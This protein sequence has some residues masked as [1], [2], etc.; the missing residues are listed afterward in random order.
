M[1]RS[2]RVSS[3]VSL[4][5]APIAAV[6][7]TQADQAAETQTQ[8]AATALQEIV[9]TAQKRSEKLHDVPMGVTA[10]TSDDLQKQDLVSFADLEAKVPGLSVEQIQPGQDRLAIRGQNVGSVGSTVTTYL[11]GVPFGSSNALANGSIVTGD[12]D[13]WDLQR[14]EVLRGPQG[15]LYGAGSEGGLLKYVTNLPDPSREAG[16]F[17]VGGEDIAHGDTTESVKGM[18]NMPITGSA[19]VRI[20][21]FYDGVP[22]YIDDPNLGKNDVNGGYRQGGHV[23]FLVQ[24]SDNFSLRLSAFGQTLH[25]DGTPY[26]DVIGAAGTPLTPP[27]NQLQPSIGDYDQMRFTNEPSTFRY[28]IFALDLDWNLGWGTLSSTSSY[29]TSIQ[30][31]YTDASSVALAP[32]FTFGDLA[33]SITGVPTGVAETNDLT[34]DKYTEELRLASSG[35]Q[36]LEW[37]VGAFYTHEAS[38]LSQSLP[39]FLIPSQANTGLPSLETP[40]LDSLYREQSVF[41][42]ITYHF[43]PQWDVALGGRWSENEQSTTETIG[44]LLVNPSQLD[45]GSSSESDFTYSIAPRWHV[46]NDTMVYARVAS[47]YRPGGPNALPPVAPAGVAASY[48]SDSTVNYELG[49]RTS[50]MDNRLSIDIDAFLVDWRKIQL[51]QIVDNF[52]INANGG[53]AESKG[54]EWTLG[55]TPVQGLNFTLTGDYVDAYLTSSA[56]AAGGNDG[57]PLPYVA[58]LSTSLDASYGWRVSSDF[59]GFA[60]AT[61]TYMGGRWDDFSAST[62][63]QAGALVSVPNPR[64]ELP[65][66]NTVNLRAGFENSR[67]T[68]LLYCKNAGDQRG[69][70]YYAN[71]GTPNFGGSIALVQPRTIGATVTLHY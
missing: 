56:P 52:G 18:I 62:Q 71:S 58:K 10:V 6:P 17:E 11:D 51:L 59:S 53:T 66:Y 42:Q 24:P 47:G 36:S 31:L 29:G 27:A 5:L 13:T 50:V 63:V 69:L 32:G 40:V 70:T 46:T 61:W 55:L 39:T 20:S 25:T 41:G 28:R 1:L 43:S 30:D 54:I 57:D 21:G 48:G 60:G 34:V 22:G 15:T 14:V 7:A 37:Q 67:W 19:A 45:V 65:S 26:I 23:S 9:V 2:P 33:A 12:F 4:L 49:T 8:P 35:T 68:F 64:L 44:G 38:I 16:A 3:L